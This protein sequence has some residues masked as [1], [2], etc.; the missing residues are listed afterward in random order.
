MNESAL[1]TLR[2]EAREKEV[3]RKAKAYGRE[4]IEKEK[5]ER[6]RLIGA[7]YVE[8]FASGT[9]TIEEIRIFEQ[10]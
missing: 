10:E 2:R 4:Q 3:E 8:P 9:P 7:I 6:I 1:E 5:A